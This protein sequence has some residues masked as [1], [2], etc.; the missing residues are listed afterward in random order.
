MHTELWAR[1]VRGVQLWE[2]QDSELGRLETKY[3]LGISL[4]AR[5]KVYYKGEGGGFLQIWAMVS[6][7]SPCLPMVRP[8]TKGAQ[9]MH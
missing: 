5:H 3:H 1:K 2:F 4:V 9:T 6:L 8:C 7:V